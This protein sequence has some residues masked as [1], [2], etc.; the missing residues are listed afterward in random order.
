VLAKSDKECSI[1]RYCRK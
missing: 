1:L